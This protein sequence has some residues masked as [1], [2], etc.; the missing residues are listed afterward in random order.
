MNNES[1]LIRAFGANDADQA[2]VPK[3]ISGRTVSRLLIG[4]EM[5][6]SFCFPHGIE[7]ANNRFSKIQRSW[8]A[9]RRHQWK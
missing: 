8:K 7:V 5:G 6:C 1:R 4:E 3:K 9:H 2:D